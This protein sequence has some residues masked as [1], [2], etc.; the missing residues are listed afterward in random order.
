MRA[1]FLAMIAIEGFGMAG[2][3]SAQPVTRYQFCIQGEE[4][5][6]WS[7]CSFNTLQ[8][9]QAAASGI[10]AE[11]LSNPWYKPGDDWT[12][13]PDG[14]PYGANGPI[15]IGPPPNSGN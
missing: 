7:G 6:G 9:C 14:N 10:Q 15:P 4:T 1:I 8:E 2:T 11:C 5:P 13:T 12:P 3:A